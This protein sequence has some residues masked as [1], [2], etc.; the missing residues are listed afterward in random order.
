VKQIRFFALLRRI[1]QK[2]GEADVMQVAA[3][4]A[5]Y[6]LF[7]L[8]PLILLLI[9]IGSILL[10]DRGSVEQILRFVGETLPGAQALVNE[11][12]PNVV[13]Q[14][15]PVGLVG[16]VTLMWSASNVFTILSA[17]INSAWP[18]S[19]KRTYLETRLAGLGIV[20]AMAI[21]LV[22]YILA[23]IL[24]QLMAWLRVPFLGNLSLSYA[25]A[26]GWIWSLLSWMLVLGL[27]FG[28]YRWVPKAHVPWQAALT[29]GVITT[30]ILLGLS[31]VLAGLLALIVQRYQ[32]IYGSLS[33][34]VAFMLYIYLA[35]LVVLTGAH[36]SAAISTYNLEEVN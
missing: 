26:W 23:T 28:I 3:S 11:N 2:V 30:L 32:L 22:G 12:I 27:L 24:L 31:R 6:T 17:H 25:A 7:S 20:G 29:S 34:F 36:I 14:R 19:G 1:A 9:S 5:F 13:Q 15:G 35:N 10:K 18:G 8:F 21:A 16:L 4:M 33:V